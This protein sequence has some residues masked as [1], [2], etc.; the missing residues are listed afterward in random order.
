MI[1]FFHHY[2][3]PVIL[4]QAQLQQLLL[5]NHAPSTPHP[6]TP[7]T[8]T[9]TP[10]PSPTP[11]SS[12]NPTFWTPINEQTLGNYIS[13]L[14]RIIPDSDLLPE[15]SNAPE[16][17]ESSNVRPAPAVVEGISNFFSCFRPSIHLENSRSATPQFLDCDVDIS[18]LIALY[19]IGGKKLLSLFERGLR[20]D[21]LFSTKSRDG[22]G[23]SLDRA[24]RSSI[25][26]DR[27]KQSRAERSAKNAPRDV[28]T[29]RKT[30]FYVR[31]IRNGRDIGRGIIDS[32][33]ADD[34]NDDDYD[35][36]N[37]NNTKYDTIENKRNRKRTGIFEFRGSL[38]EKKKTG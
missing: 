30:S 9:S 6:P 11:T 26:R 16:T 5:R 2:E 19:F 4:Q 3:L 1:Y 28:G 36:N 37:N 38:K 31:G 34:D 24:N 32:H 29:N 14:P 23:E 17:N 27:R 10:G 7:S 12:S 8:G 33:V 35:R 21:F 22:W 20:L 25:A 13:E 15:R 18:K